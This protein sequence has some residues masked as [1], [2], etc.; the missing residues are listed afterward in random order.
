MALNKSMD[1]IFAQIAQPEGSDPRNSSWGAAAQYFQPK[2]FRDGWIQSTDPADYYDWPGYERRLQDATDLMAGK[3]SPDHFPFWTIWPDPTTA[4]AVAMQRQ[5]ITDYVSQNAL[6]FVTGAKD[7]EA[8]W[9][10]Y[11]AGLEQL[12]LVGYLATMQA[13][14]DVSVAK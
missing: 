14:Y 5:N 10:D 8:D 13:A 1:A 12:D 4:D 9:D 11:V 6:E 2:T 3:E 7:L